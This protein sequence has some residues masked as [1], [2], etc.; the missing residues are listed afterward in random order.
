MFS[1]WLL[2]ESIFLFFFFPLKE[3]YAMI[4]H[5]FHQLLFSRLFLLILQNFIYRSSTKLD[6]T[7]QSFLVTFTLKVATVLTFISIKVHNL[8]SC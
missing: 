4:F 3:Q 2:E 8:L 1:E 6:L 5:T 7:L